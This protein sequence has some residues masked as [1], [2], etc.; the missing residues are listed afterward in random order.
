MVTGGTRNV[1]LAIAEA[2]G[3]LGYQVVLAYRSDAVQAEEAVRRLGRLG[4]PGRASRADVTDEADVQRLF[5]EIQNEAY[6]P[7]H[8]ASYQLDH[9]LWGLHPAG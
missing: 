6:Q 9:A 1:G 8:I 2:L 7:L 5:G 3:G 4:T